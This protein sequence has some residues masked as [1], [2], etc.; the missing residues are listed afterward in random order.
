MPREV[1]QQR[2]T[3]AR[4]A[5][6]PAALV[7][8]AEDDAVAIVT[9]D[10]AATR[11]ALSLAMIDALAAVFD[12]LA[13]RR[14]IR[15]IVVQG[16]G[17]AFCAGHDLKELTAHRADA[18]GG[19]AFYA[20]TMQACS[21]M[22]RRIVAQPQPVI[23]AVDGMATAAG[24]QLVAS[25]DLAV[26]GPQARFCTPGVDIG[27]FCSTPAVALSRNIPRKL[28][29]EMLLTG[30]VIGAEDALRFGLVNRV[31]PSGARDGAATLA[32]KIAGKSAQAIAVGKRA[33]Y[34]Q[35]E[36]PLSAAYDHA[37]AV[38]TANMM[39]ADARE[40]VSAFL[41]KRQPIWTAADA[42]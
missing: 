31:A 34:Q 23:A 42:P 32:R 2:E 9:L 35:L 25:C 8:L 17:A 33:F 15:A 5:A 29:M 18:D 36:M 22:M 37:S 13:R 24:C 38:M 20:R 3:A 41:E 10:S 7:S 39:L 6:T 40:G 28:A 21:D 11:N 1:I 19:R 27:L 14:E 16:E 4:H 12:D 26:A 30:D